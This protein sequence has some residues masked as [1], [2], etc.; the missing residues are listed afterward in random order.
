MR[1]LDQFKLEG[2]IALLSGCSRG[3]GKAMALAEAGADIIGV[4]A[5]QEK[6]GSQVEREVRARGRDFRGYACDFSNREALYAFIKQVQ[7]DFPTIDILVN[8]AGIILRKPAVEHPDEYWD[9]TIE[10]NLNAQ[11]ILSREN[12]RWWLDGQ[13]V[14]TSSSNGKG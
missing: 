2:K 3:I 1:I 13:V 8:N 9:K 10:V 12:G 11:F 5:S 14:Q 7:A 4:S 6:T